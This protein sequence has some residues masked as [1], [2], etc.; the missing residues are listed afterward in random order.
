M[1]KRGASGKVFNTLSEVFGLLAFVYQ[2]T[3]GVTI[4]IGFK[5]PNP[6][7]WLALG[8]LLLLL[9]ILSFALARACRVISEFIS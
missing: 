3:G 8:I 4:Q 6:A 2:V 7:P 5:Q 9:S 1:A